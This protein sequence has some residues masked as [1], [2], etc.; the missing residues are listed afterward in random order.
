MDSAEEA[1]RKQFMEA[2]NAEYAELQKDPEA[3]ADYQAEL[4][5][6]DVT[7]MDGLDKDEIWDSETRTAHFR[8][9]K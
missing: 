5:L 3:W 7:L 1:R 9:S 6:W 4:K 2:L 8:S